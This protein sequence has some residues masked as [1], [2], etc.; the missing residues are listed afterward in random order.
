MRLLTADE[1]EKKAKACRRALGPTDCWFCKREMAE[2][3]CLECEYGCCRRCSKFGD[4][5]LCEGEGN[6]D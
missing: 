5:P 2:R 1:L 4:C 6:Y 3:V